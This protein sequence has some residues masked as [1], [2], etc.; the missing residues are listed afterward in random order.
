MEEDEDRV[1]ITCNGETH[2]FVIEDIDPNFLQTT[3][4]LLESPTTLFS[5][6][7]NLA[8]PIAKKTK[9]L[10]SGGSYYIKV[11]R[12]ISG[13][14]DDSYDATD[15]LDQ[16]DDL[17]VILNCLILSTAIYFPYDEGGILNGGECGGYLT[18]QLDNHNFEYFV[19]NRFGENPFL[20][21]KVN[22]KI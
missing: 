18:E 21:A 20:I 12:N 22:C 17:D 15:L 10:K 19:R 5:V 1:S 11:S 2:Q 9:R 8:I 13:T 14:V 3:F 7:S 6:S 4:N 16:H